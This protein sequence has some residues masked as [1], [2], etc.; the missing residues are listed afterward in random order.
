[1][2]AKSLVSRA[3]SLLESSFNIDAPSSFID[4]VTLYQ[5]L[6]STWNDYSS[7]ISP[8]ELKHSL[9]EHV[10][11]SLSLVP[12]IAPEIA[13]GK[14]YVDI[15]SGGGFPAIPIAI[16]FPTAK[17]LLVERKRRKATFL[18]KVIASL[19]LQCVE[20][21]NVSFPTDVSLPQ[22][23]ILTARAIERPDTFLNALAPT[24]DRESIF[25]RQTGLSPSPLPQGLQSN[26]VED[27]FDSQGL[28]RG[29]LFRVT[30]E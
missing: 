20:L 29:I 2:P 22:P 30:K 10:A 23:A 3:L 13:S 19:R 21:A 1:M 11:D 15:G 7:L 25:L 27:L 6:L 5:G 8:V 28:R 17:I 4:S 14:V 16:L 9:S 26:R 18:R 12:Y 24:M